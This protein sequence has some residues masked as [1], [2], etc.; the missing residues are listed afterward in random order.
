MFGDAL[1]YFWKVSALPPS[2]GWG[3]QVLVLVPFQASGVRCLSFQSL[4]FAVCT[5]CKL[6]NL[7]GLFRR[8]AC[9]TSTPS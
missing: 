3:Y 8:V 1:C 2:G 6:V 7:A 9:H 4:V 5:S